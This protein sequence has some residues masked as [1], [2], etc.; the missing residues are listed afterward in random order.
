V[1]MLISIPW[2]FSSVDRPIIR[3]IEMG[4]GG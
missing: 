3:G 1:L 4:T 2:P